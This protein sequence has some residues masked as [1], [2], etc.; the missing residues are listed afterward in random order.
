MKFLKIRLI[1]V[2]TVALAITAILVPVAM[3]ATSNSANLGAQ[4]IST[5]VEYGPNETSSTATVNIPGAT[6]TITIPSG[7]T[8]LLVARFSGDS[9]CNFGPAGSPCM[10]NLVYSKPGVYAEFKPG[11]RVFDTDDTG[12]NYF[13]SHATQGIAGPLSAGTY[14][15]SAMWKVDPPCCGTRFKLQNT[16]LTVEAWRAS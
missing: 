8:A 7:Q 9:I 10:V 12:D 1:A 2:G 15:V 13:E 14:T 4:R 5:V 11:L 16:V 6:T 3:A